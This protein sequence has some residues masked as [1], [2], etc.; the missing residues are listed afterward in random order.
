MKKSF[1]LLQTLALSLVSV[2]ATN[3]TTT[4]ASERVVKIQI[5]S[6]SATING[7]TATMDVAPYIENGNTMIPIRFVAN[8]LDISDENISYDDPTRT[9]HIVKDD[10]TKF[11]FQI[12]SGTIIT[13]INGEEVERVMANDAQAEIKDS[14]TFIPFRE[15]ANSFELDIEWDNDTRTVTLI[16]QVEEEIIETIE[17]TIENTEELEEV[18]EVGFIDVNEFIRENVE[19]GDI[20]SILGPSASEV[21][22]AEALANGT[23][24][25]SSSDFS[26]SN[27]FVDVND[28]I[29]ANVN[30]DG[31]TT[32]S[33][34]SFTS[35]SGEIDLDAYMNAIMGSNNSYNNY[36]TGVNDGENVGFDIDAF[37]NGSD[38][39]DYDEDDY[40][41]YNSNYDND[42]YS[43]NSDY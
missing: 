7:E 30:I 16:G 15:L 26:D 19:K 39:D 13:V 29:N 40:Y 22:A 11:V 3:I 34:D 14:R 5:D 4:F 41:Y 37:L 20:E 17:E 31:S 9:V 42:D 28:Y 2:I 6:V 38:E 27:G 33:N 35:S 18:Q 12:D 36:Y 32:S 43:N 23:T 25:N 24:N 1:R 8:A 21:A 10:T